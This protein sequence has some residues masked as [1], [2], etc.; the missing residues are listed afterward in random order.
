MR[1]LYDDHYFDDCERGVSEA[2][3]RHCLVCV[4]QFQATTSAQRVY[5]SMYARERTPPAEVVILSRTFL[6]H[7]NKCPLNSTMHSGLLV[8]VE[9][10][11]C[12]CAVLEQ[13]MPA[14]MCR[15]PI[16]HCQYLITYAWM[17]TYGAREQKTLKCVV[18]Y[19]YTVCVFSIS[20][21]EKRCSKAAATMYIYAMRSRE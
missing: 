10:A 1:I 17:K 2:V 19:D 4:G 20:S 8:P 9:W 7:N 12:C 21:L 15:N 18:L 11:E 5:V 13:R 16:R 6:V 3:S 14:S